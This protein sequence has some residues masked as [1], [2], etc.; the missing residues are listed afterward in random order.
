MNEIASAKQELRH[1]AAARRRSIPPSQLESSGTELENMAAPFIDELPQAAAIAAYISMG[2]EIQTLP[3][4]RYILRSDRPVLVPRLGSGMEIGWSEIA[5]IEELDQLTDM[6]RRASG[7]LRP[8]EPTDTVTLSPDALAEAA[9]ILVP[10]FAID[11][12]GIRLGRGAGWYDQALIHRN[13]QSTLLGICW[14]WEQSE[15]PLPAHDHDVPVH[16]ILTTDSFR[17]L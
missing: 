6:P 12:R 7:G 17:L 1:A 14:P 16:G 5:D 3:L 15:E 4:L 13:P 11:N 9:C 8:Q 2:T 10:A